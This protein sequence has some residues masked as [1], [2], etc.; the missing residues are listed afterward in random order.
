MMPVTVEK[1]E[2]RL[3][4]ARAARVPE[5]ELQE[6]CEYLEELKMGRLAS[7]KDDGEMYK[8]VEKE[9]ETIVRISTA[10]MTS[11]DDDFEGVPF[12]KVPTQK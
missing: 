9:E 2:A 5:N 6:L 4:E 3:Q 11:D 8:K 7:Q 1:I 10:P 12:K